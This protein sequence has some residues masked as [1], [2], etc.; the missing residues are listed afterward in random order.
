M[1]GQFPRN[2]HCSGGPLGSIFLLFPMKVAGDQAHSS[3]GKSPPLALRHSP[4]KCLSQREL[5]VLLM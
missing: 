2:L 1:S 3:Q 4:E 5:A